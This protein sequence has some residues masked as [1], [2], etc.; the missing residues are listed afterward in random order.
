MHRRRRA[1]YLPWPVAV[2]QEHRLALLLTRPSTA[3]HSTPSTPTTFNT[4]PLS[5]STADPRYHFRFLVFMD[6]L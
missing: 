4:P 6:V 1:R 5:T 2:A 3:R